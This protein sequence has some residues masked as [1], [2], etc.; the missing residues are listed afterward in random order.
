MQVVQKELGRKRK[1][2]IK[3]NEKSK[4]IKQLLSLN[5]EQITQYQK[6]FERNAQKIEESKRKMEFLKNFIADVKIN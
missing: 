2:K 1:D 5:E 4:D 3:T 6:I